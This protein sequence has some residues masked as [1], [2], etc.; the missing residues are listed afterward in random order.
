MNKRIFWVIGIIAA[1]V[2]ISAAIILT[3]V[4]KPWESKSASPKSE[5]QATFDEASEK[6]PL[7]SSALDASAL[8]G[9]RLRA[10]ERI[11]RDGV[12]VAETVSSDVS[13]PSV[14]VAAADATTGLRVV[15]GSSEATLACHVTLEGM[16]E[17]EELRAVVSLVD[18]LTGQAATDAAGRAASARRSFRR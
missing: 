14:A 10:R 11:L 6:A 3:A 17:D 2:V 13:V 1:G 12:V 16:P 8:A 4:F 15:Q 18:A 9:R 7:R 5:S